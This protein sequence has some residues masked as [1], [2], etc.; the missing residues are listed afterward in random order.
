MIDNMIMLL[1]GTLN[2]PDVD[3]NALIEQCHPMGMFDEG[4]M[5]SMAAFENTG[6]GYVDL[7]ET[8]LIDTPVGAALGAP[9]PPRAPAHP[10]GAGKYF[11][12]FLKAQTISTG[13]GMEVRTLLEE[14]ALPVLEHSVRK[15]YLEDFYAFCQE[16]GGEVRAGGRSRD[17]QAGHRSNRRSPPLPQTA[18]VMGEVLRARAD[19]TTIMITLNSMSGPLNEEH[20]LKERAA[21]YPSF[22]SLYEAGYTAIAAARDEESLG[23]ALNAH[24]QFRELWYE[25]TNSDSKSLVDIFYERDVMIMENAFESQSHFGA[26]LCRAGGLPLCWVFR[27]DTLRLPPSAPLLLAGCFYAFV[28]LREQEIRNLGWIAECIVQR[29]HSHIGDHLVRIFSNQSPWRNR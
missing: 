21:L 18:L 24:A 20:N 16:L 29:M 19:A 11:A 12:E 17:G 14:V 10:H 13:Q 7:Y 6:Q 15:L 9:A 3:V 2:N 8:V 22:G 1:R 28:K 23:R 27:A 5:R 26:S 4:V 25:Y